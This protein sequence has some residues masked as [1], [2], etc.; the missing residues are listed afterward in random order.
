MTPKEPIFDVA[1]LAHVELL[2]PKIE[3]SVRFFVDIMGMVESSRK[4]DSVYLRGWDDYE[5]HSLQLTAATQSGLG[6][7]ALRAA[8]PQAL[9][10]RVAALEESGL[11]QGWKDDNVGHGPAYCFTD[12]DL[13][14]MEIYYE[15]E[16]YHPPEG[17][18]PALKNQASRY[19]DRGIGLR[20]IDHINLLAADV[21]ACRIL[22]QDALGG[23][24]TEQIIFD[25]GSEKASWLTFTNKTYDVAISEDW[26]G[27]KGR[28]HHLTYAVDS[29][30]EILRAADICLEH[31]VFME[32]GPSKHAIQQT[33]FLYVYEPGGNRFEIANAGARLLLA[34]DWQT[35]IWSE[36]E[37][38]K[39]QAWGLPTIPSFHTHGTPPVE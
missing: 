38:K 15:T 25:D 21:R 4:G 10:R 19:P 24:M 30:E 18:C 17:L 16:W 35:V 2:T 22:L 32:T 39:G 11:G 9:Q 29:R 27:S 6:H 8:S 1:H 3:E 26:T 36:A 31:N 28:L 23:R 34:P 13:H 7:Y 20:R 12:P 37:R 33:F 14:K 5:H